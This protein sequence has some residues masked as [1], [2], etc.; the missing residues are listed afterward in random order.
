[1]VHAC[2]ACHIAFLLSLLGLDQRLA[3]RTAPVKAGTP[4][5]IAQVQAHEPVCI[6]TNPG[7]LWLADPIMGDDRG[8]GRRPK[9][10]AQATYTTRGRL[11]RI[12]QAIASAVANTDLSIRLLPTSKPSIGTKGI[13]IS[14][15]S[16]ALSVV[17][18]AVASV[19]QITQLAIKH[20]ETPRRRPQNYVHRVPLSAR[21]MQHLRIAN[22]TLCASPKA[23]LMPGGPIERLQV[24]LRRA[25][26]A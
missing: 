13:K 10:S 1:V 19:T 15:S 26:K 8:A 7:D 11:L 20:F 21:G 17:S 25:E 14:N 12:L 24:I 23:C 3:S 22:R 5:L 4:W 9:P 16:H 6:F 2:G 18:I